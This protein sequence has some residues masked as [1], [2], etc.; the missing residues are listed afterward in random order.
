MTKAAK[1]WLITAGVL[2]VAGGGI[3][4]GALAADGWSLN[5]VEYK[6]N[7]IE[8]NADFKS[9]CIDM[10]SADVVFKKAA[11][12]KC[13]VEFYETD[14]IKHTAAV[15]N[16]TLFIG[17]NDKRNW[18]DYFIPSMFKSAKATVYLPSNEYASLTIDCTTGST[19]I[20][21]GFAFTEI[22]INKTTGKTKINGVKADKLAVDVTTGDV[23]LSS[24]KVKGDINIKST[25]G[26]VDLADT[27]AGGKLTINTTTG[28]VKLN[29]CDAGEIAIK[30]TT[31]DVEGTLLTNK[32]FSVDTTTGDID[33]PD[34]S[35]S[36]KCNIST[37]TGDVEIEIVN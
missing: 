15:N 30:L 26:D 23:S 9:I 11:D 25:T 10:T 3:C 17:E 21:E 16:G 37:T 24:V 7:K 32:V 5:T 19:E 13:S 1:I 6:T 33:V 4:I 14:R 29:R 36:N 31:G 12:N 27:V 8:V 18:Y 22:S 2:T 35:G 20:P 34:S 28:D